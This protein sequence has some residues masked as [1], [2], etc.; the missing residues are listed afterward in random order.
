MLGLANDRDVEHSTTTT[1]TG[2]RSA[3]WF[4]KMQT[5]DHPLALTR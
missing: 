3:D 4:C 5:A 1:M 2:L